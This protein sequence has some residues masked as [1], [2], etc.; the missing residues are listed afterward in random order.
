M[1]VENSATS[2]A[3]KQSPISFPVKTDNLTSGK[4]E[5]SYKPLPQVQMPVFLIG[6]D[7]YS[8]CWLK[9]HRNELLKLNA[10]GL[11]V[12]V[13]TEENYRVIVGIGQGLPIVPM[14]GADIASN[15]G[16]KHYPVLISQQGIEQ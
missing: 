4:I 9:Q 15:L 16:I 7:S 8:R 10:L 11:L 1:E 3:K 12:D 5:S 6:D 14:S 13:E 2:N